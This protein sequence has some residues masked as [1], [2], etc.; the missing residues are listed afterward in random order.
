MK[1]EKIDNTAELIKKAFEE[2]NNIDNEEYQRVVKL[3][4]KRKKEDL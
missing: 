2:S 3:I 1:N 4:E